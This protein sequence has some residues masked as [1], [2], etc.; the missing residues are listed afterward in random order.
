M[1]RQRQRSSSGW[2][3]SLRFLVG[4]SHSGWVRLVAKVTTAL[5]VALT[6]VIITFLVS[7]RH[8]GLQ[9]RDGHLYLGAFEIGQFTA[10]S[11]V[12]STETHQDSTSLNR[13]PF[14]AQ[15]TVESTAGFQNSGIY[16]KRGDR[17]ILRPGGRINL[18]LRQVYAFTGLVK[19]LIADRLPAGSELN[20][21]YKTR[22]QLRDPE[23]GEALQNLTEIEV[24]QRLTTIGEFGQRETFHR[25]W[26]GPDGEE[27]SSEDLDPCLLFRGNSG[28]TP[29][30]GMLLAQVLEDPGAATADPFQVLRLNGLSSS[31]LI[32]VSS[33]EN[34]TLEAERDG[35]L[36]FVINEAVL[37]GA[38][39][40]SQPVQPQSCKDYHDVLADVANTF[41]AED[42]RNRYRIVERSIP[43]IWFSDNIGA[44][45]VIVRYADESS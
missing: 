11:E 40:D 23:T 17:V 25:D 31:D 14:G 24:L 9:V 34:S 19:P 42:Y 5:L 10:A 20:D 45:Q 29:R 8:I 22:N 36:A 18:A 4:L 35:W 41:R 26:I 38:M 2:E 15:V 32:P 28:V 37:S 12:Q 30:W 27:V 39:E 16:L 6:I 7:F 21:R 3:R 1:Q 33:L 13:Q 44:F 43:L